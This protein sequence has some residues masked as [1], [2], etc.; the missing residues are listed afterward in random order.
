MLIY[1]VNLIFVAL[2]GLIQNTNLLVFEG[3]KPNLVLV[4][5]L[6][7]G[8]FYR[9]WFRRIIFILVGAFFLKFSPVIEVEDLFFITAVSAGLFFLDYLPWRKTIS[10]T[11]VLVLAT[12]ILN[13]RAFSLFRFSVELLMNLGFAALFLLIFKWTHAKEK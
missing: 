4:L 1:I 7:L 2:A 5:L 11:T 13:L 10:F 12:L 3:V 9:N 6:T 8:F